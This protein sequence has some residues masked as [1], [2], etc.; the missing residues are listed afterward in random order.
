M[1][2][3]SGTTTKLLLPYPIPDDTVDVPRDVKALADRL[4]L[5]SPSYLSGTYAARP[6]ASTLGRMYIATD[7]GGVYLDTGAKWL[8]LSAPIV[9]ALPTVGVQDNDEIHLNVDIGQGAVTSLWHCRYDADVAD[10]YKWYVLDG[11]PLMVRADAGR[12]TAAAQSAYGA[13]PTDPL[14]LNLPNNGIWDVTIQGSCWSNAS[15]VANVAL[16]YI[17]NGV[18]AS[19]A[20]AIVGGM[21]IMQA[22]GACTTRHTINGADL[23]ILERARA[24]STASHTGTF[25]NRRIFAKPVRII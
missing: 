4:E 6:T 16:S 22:S 7:T 3:P 21:G 13:L 17:I 15:A 18:A 12:S 19:D 1:A 2:G 23:R 20:W 24:S 25:G 10:A 5:I 9:S 11:D 8:T 14:Q